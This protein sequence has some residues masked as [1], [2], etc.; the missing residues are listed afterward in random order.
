MQNAAN[1]STAIADDVSLMS[2]CD[3]NEMAIFGQIIAEILHVGMPVTNKAIISAL[4][5]RLE[6]ES[7][8]IKLDIYR[9]LLE[10]VVHKT[11]DDFS[12]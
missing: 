10:L 11:P 7:D 6:Q 8:V 9:N 5:A 1:S 12:L 3:S 2:N 4:I